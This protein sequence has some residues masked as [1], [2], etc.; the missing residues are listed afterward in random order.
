VEEIRLKTKRTPESLFDDIAQDN[1]V[2]REFKHH[3]LRVMYLSSLLAKKVNYYDEDLRTASL[4]HD[5]GKIGISKE[6]LM[7]PGKL[8]SL[9]KT[10]IESHCHVGNRIVRKELG[11]TR[12]AEFVRDH[13][14]NWDGTGYPRQLIGEEISV[15]GRIIRISD[16]FDT[17]TYDVRNYSRAKMSSHDAFQELRRCS[18]IQ[19]DGN[20]VEEL[21]SLLIKIK[22]PEF[23]Y[24]DK[25]FM[26]KLKFI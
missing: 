24:D 10:I 22:L 7:K 4:L 2:L 15:Q 25:K 17:M 19:F 6:I 20:L 8:N 26:E 18:W 14:E 1:E 12:A 23:W 11:K 21:I 3:S 13:H 5:I 9:E 16:S